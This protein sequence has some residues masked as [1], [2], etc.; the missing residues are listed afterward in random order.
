M[1]AKKPG[2]LGRFID[3]L[4]GANEEAKHAA[5]QGKLAKALKAG[6]TYATTRAQF[7]Q[8]SGNP[9][10]RRFSQTV[11]ADKTRRE[12]LERQRQQSESLNRLASDGSPTAGMDSE[13]FLHRFRTYL[14]GPINADTM[15]TF[16]WYCQAQGLNR[17]AGS[18]MLGALA[19]GYN[20]RRTEEVEFGDTEA[21]S[22]ATR[23]WVSAIQRQVPDADSHDVAVMFSTAVSEQEMI[24]DACMSL[25]L[26][27]GDVAVRNV[28]RRTTLKL[29][30]NPGASFTAQPRGV[31]EEDTHR[32]WAFAYALR[33]VQPILGR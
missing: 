33:C 19:I 6:D 13:R 18:F 20:A 10:T 4:I 9:E 29:L 28:I 3:G 5:P 1:G 26:I 15:S 16:Q 23:P 30:T 22:G 14:D 12:L 21:V 2:R 7:G 11:L 8:Y 31:S 32:A 17:D 24:S 25:D 27:P